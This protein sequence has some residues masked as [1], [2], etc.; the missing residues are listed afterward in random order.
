MR[1][2]WRGRSNGHGDV[3]NGHEGPEGDEP[4]LVEAAGDERALARAHYEPE[5]DDDGDEGDDFE[6]EGEEARLARSFGRLAAGGTGP[7]RPLQRQRRRR[8]G[9]GGGG[10]KAQG[11][12][13]G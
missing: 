12:G 5:G 2:E 7:A 11:G 8:R 9:E 13:E 10:G 6:P 3:H 4:F 1:S